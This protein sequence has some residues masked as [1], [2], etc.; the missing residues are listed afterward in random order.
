MAKAVKM[1]MIVMFIVASVVSADLV[2][3]LV[4]PI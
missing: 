4:I 1:L 2:I 3:I